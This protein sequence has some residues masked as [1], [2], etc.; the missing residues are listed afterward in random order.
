MVPPPFLLST[1]T[2]FVSF[3]AV[4]PLLFFFRCTFSR[5]YRFVVSFL[6]GSSRFVSVHNVSHGFVSF[7][8]IARQLVENACRYH[9]TKSNA[10]DVQLLRELIDSHR[11]DAKQRQVRRPLMPFTKDCPPTLSPSRE[12]SLGLDGTT[13]G[14]RFLV[15]AW[16]NG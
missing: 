5:S 9:T 12:A 4:P 15:G 16:M 14:V 1:S 7:R 13:L 10:V 2:R 6:V 3:R 11:K 8:F